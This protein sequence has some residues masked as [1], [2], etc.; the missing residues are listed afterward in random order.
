M[1]TPKKDSPLAALNTA[2]VAEQQRQQQAMI[3]AALGDQYP[4]WLK[5]QKSKNVKKMG[6]F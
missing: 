6:S 1:D 3:R 4:A 5:Q 2:E